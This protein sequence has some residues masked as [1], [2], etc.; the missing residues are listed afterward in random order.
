MQVLL[1]TNILLRWVDTSDPDS[2]RVIAAVE[3]L[4]A[5]GDVLCY[6]SQNLG[7][8]WNVLTRPVDRNGYG[9]SATGANRRAPIIESR[10]QLIPDTP[11]VH[12]EWRNMLV[13]HNVCGSQVH[14]A[15]LAAAMRVNGIQRILMLNPRDFA[16]FSGIQALHPAQVA[17]P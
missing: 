8:F 2:A 6:T 7:E 11:A 10:I 4:L 14:D 5:S 16:R 3:H 13:A 1:D 15:R 9:L 17:K 12:I